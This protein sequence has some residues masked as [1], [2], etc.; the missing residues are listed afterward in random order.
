MKMKFKV[1]T[2]KINAILS[3][4]GKGVGDSNVLPIVRYINITLDKR[5]LVITATDSVNFITYTEKGVKGTEGTATVLASRLIKLASKTTKKEMSFELKDGHLHVKGNGNYTLENNEAEQFPTFDFN[6]KKRGNKIDTATLKKALKINESA[7]AREMH[8]P[9]LTGFNMGDNV[10]TTDGVKMCINDITVFKKERVLVPQPLAT[11]LEQ[12][13][14]E[15][16]T[17]VKDENKLLFKTDA[18]EI[19]GVTLDGIEEFPD[20]TP[21]ADLEHDNNIN[22]NRAELTESLDRM[23]IFID[24]D[25]NYGVTLTFEKEQL[26]LAD[27]TGENKETVEY[28]KGTNVKSEVTVT[29]SLLYLVDLLSSM[30]TNV[31]TVG[32]D[33]ESPVKISEDG[34]VMVLAV[35]NDV[36]EEAMEDTGEPEPEEDGD[37]QEDNIDIE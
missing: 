33:E 12:L 7:I 27:S 32:V 2:A 31:V 30:Q 1:H 37:L 17:I 8:M 29:V 9:C 22:V 20:I 5:G 25:S 21:L 15:K 26:T 36:D 6:R 19:F 34:I 13:S 35:I 18:I 23:S 24:S 14:E 16:V 3:R 10:T 4:V 11:L 28:Q